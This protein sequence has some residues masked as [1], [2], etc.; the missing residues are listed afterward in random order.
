LRIGNV[1][2]CWCIVYIY[3]SFLLFSQRVPT[4]SAKDKDKQPEPDNQLLQLAFSIFDAEGTGSIALQGLEGV[5]KVLGQKVNRDELRATIRA[6]RELTQSRL[7]NNG[8]IN[9][10]DEGQDGNDKLF[11]D[12]FVT[13]MST[14][15]EEDDIKNVWRI[16]D[17]E[18]KGQIS[19]VD[20]SQVMEV[21]SGNTEKLTGEQLEKMMDLAQTE[22][23]L[24]IKYQHFKKWWQ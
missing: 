23:Q 16:L 3:E 20:L 2:L 15:I 10:G 14:P 22:D 4:M 6:L 17:S 8:A 12:D 1:C 7:G 24:K 9:A 18:K 11:W 21:L 13:L 19:M 5:L